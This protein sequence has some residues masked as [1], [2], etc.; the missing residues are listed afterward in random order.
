LQ[1]DY[2]S[3]TPAGS[4]QKHPMNVPV[5]WSGL[6]IN[7]V[8]QKEKTCFEIAQTETDENLRPTNV[9]PKNSSRF[10]ACKDGFLEPHAFNK[11]MV[12]ITGN[13][14]AYT[15]QNVDEYEYE[16]PVLKTDIIYIWR[17][18]RPNYSYFNSYASFAPF[19]CYRSYISGYCY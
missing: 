7:T 16:Y 13:L 10:I 15:K 19:H 6:I 1:G 18:Y 4:K 14:V 9:I 5:R 2:S 3:L 8:N 12:T 17:N 11:R